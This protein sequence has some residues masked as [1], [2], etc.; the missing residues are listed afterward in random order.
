MSAIESILKWPFLA[1]S[2]LSLLH[3][4][5]NAAERQYFCTAVT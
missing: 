2:R 3:L 1:D 4:T 5:R